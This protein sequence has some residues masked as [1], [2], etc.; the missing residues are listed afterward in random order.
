MKASWVQWKYTDRASLVITNLK[1]LTGLRSRA[2]AGYPVE[3]IRRSRGSR[4]MYLVWVGRYSSEEEAR[5][6]IPRI[7]QQQNV[8][9]MVVS[10]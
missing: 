4:T 10:R 7:R 8:S 6:Q 5:A 2:G 1:T 9:P 3:I